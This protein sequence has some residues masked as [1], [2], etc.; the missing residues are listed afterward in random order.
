MPKRIRTQHCITDAEAEQA[1]EIITQL[2]ALVDDL[3]AVYGD[4]I[5]SLRM[6]ELEDG[7]MTSADDM[8]YDDIPF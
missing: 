1:S 8:N 6:A 2:H 7:S 3:W 5:I 4:R